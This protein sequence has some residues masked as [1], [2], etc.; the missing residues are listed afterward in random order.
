MF[1][2]IVRNFST[3]AICLVLAVIVA[4]IIANMVRKKM[5]GQ[6][7]SCDCGCTDCPSAS[8]CHDKK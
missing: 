1:N 5:R 8:V 4:L 2:F 7:A 3:I 6:P